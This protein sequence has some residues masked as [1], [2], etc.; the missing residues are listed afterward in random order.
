MEL[1][2]QI[3]SP[4]L[5]TQ[6]APTEEWSSQ[7][8][9]AKRGESDMHEKPVSDQEGM[10][11]EEMMTA[12]TMLEQNQTEGKTL[13]VE[14]A[15]EMEDK[16]Q[17]EVLNRRQSQRLKN[18]GAGDIK[19]ADK[20]GVLKERKNLLGTTH[21][22]SQNSFAV[23]SNDSLITISNLMGV[24]TPALYIDHFDVLRELEKA[25]SNLEERNIE[26][27]SLESNIEDEALPL[28]ESKLIVWQ[29]DESEDDGFEIV[30]SKKKKKKKSAKK[31]I[32]T[33]KTNPQ[34]SDGGEYCEGDVPKTCSRY[35]L[36]K[37]AV[38]KT[39]SNK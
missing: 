18:Q 19:I 16:S 32:I 27:S 26:G 8:D 39:S 17:E 33:K 23:L 30:T 6:E 28:E 9:G 12:Q 10:W 29:S 3:P 11:M 37:H 35:N 14:E 21:H 15:A 22:S 4:N 38:A 7:E 2:T 24:N 13:V 36:R 20:A 25:R 31:G 1:N 5:G 34:P